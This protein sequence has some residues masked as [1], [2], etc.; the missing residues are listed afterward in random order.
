[1]DLWEVGYRFETAPEGGPELVRREK[2]DLDKERTPLEGGTDMIVTDR[3]GDLRLR[4]LDGTTWKD[5]WDTRTM[6]R[7]P[8]AVE[9]RL[10]LKEGPVYLTSVEV[11]R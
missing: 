1:M 7:L 11:G 9:I 4:Y 10:V 6:G 5:E 8:R 3:I 2:R